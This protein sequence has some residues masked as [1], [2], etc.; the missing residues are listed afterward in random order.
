MGKN[1]AR[2][3]RRC[4]GSSGAWHLRGCRC[5]AK[6]SY[7]PEKCGY[8]IPSFKNQQAGM[9]VLIGLITAGYVPPPAS[10][11][12]T[13]HC[14]SVSCNR[15]HSYSE[16][17]AFILEIQNKFLADMCDF[18]GQEPGNIPSSGARQGMGCRG[19]DNV[20]AWDCLGDGTCR[21]LKKMVL[22]MRLVLHSASNV[23]PFAISPDSGRSHDESA[24]CLLRRIVR[25]CAFSAA[26]LAIFL[27]AYDR[28][29]AWYLFKPNVILIT[30][31]SLRPDHLGCY[32]YMRATAPIDRIASEGLSSRIP[33]LPV[34][35]PCRPSLPDDLDASPRP[36]R[37]AGRPEAAVP[38]AVAR[39]GREGRGFHHRRLRQPP[40]VGDDG[41]GSPAGSTPSTIR[42]L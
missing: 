21:M 42:T 20:G 13:T 7:E 38:A 2:R 37:D 34:H 35:G 18:R 36:P 14:P 11:T 17:A 41:S 25:A 9:N 26:C 28:F 19:M 5:A 15:K 24:S 16:M 32:G 12:D 1:Y 3:R 29:T 8:N 27:L 40:V 39:R 31:D 22:I 4:T 6:H 33:S 23:G 30:S 10:R